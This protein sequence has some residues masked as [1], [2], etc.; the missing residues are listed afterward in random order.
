MN[1]TTNWLDVDV[2]LL[3]MVTV[4]VEIPLTVLTSPPVMVDPPN[5]IELVG[6]AAPLI[7]S[8]TQRTLA[9]PTGVGVC[10]GGVWIGLRPPFWLNCADATETGKASIPKRA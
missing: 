8:A 3:V 7:P 4:I 1:V 5:V 2:V 6:S 10:V 9:K